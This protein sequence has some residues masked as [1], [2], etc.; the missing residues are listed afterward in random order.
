MAILW[1]IPAAIGPLLP[2]AKWALWAAVPIVFFLNSYFG[3]CIAALQLIT[4]NRMRAQVSALLL[5]M[6]NLFG[7]ALGPSLVAA[8]TDFV[9]VD[10]AA[11][12][13]SLALLPVVVCPLAAGLLAWGLKYY[14][15]ALSTEAE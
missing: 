11:L 5:F 4:P 15:A 8:M 6:T 13:Q 3:V 14:R 10:D 2:S 1:M 7:L 12:G 9:F